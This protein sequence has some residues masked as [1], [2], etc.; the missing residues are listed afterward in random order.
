MNRQFLIGF[1]I[2][3]MTT[4]FYSFLNKGGERIQVGDRV[5]TF[6]LLDQDGNKFLIEDY[7]GKTAMVI[8]FYPKDNTTGCIK[9]AC[10][11]R[12]NYESFKE[13][14][15]KII[16]ISSDDVKSHKAFVTKYNLPFTLLADVDNEVRERFGVPNSLFGVIPG[17]VSYVIDE[18]GVVINIYESLLKPQRHIEES[19]DVLKNR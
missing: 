14:G 16:G 13:I 12:D 11:F 8:Y 15:V 1:L 3:V 17:R 7:I 19:L 5:P 6:T 9:E 10:G 4:F 18:N 2:V